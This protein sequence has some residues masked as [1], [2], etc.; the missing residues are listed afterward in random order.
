[1]IY[2]HSHQL[3][4]FFLILFGRPRFHGQ[5]MNLGHKFR[6]GVIDGSMPFKQGHAGKLDTHNNQFQLGS[7]ATTPGNV[8]A[9]HKSGFQGGFALV[10]SRIKKQQGKSDVT[11]KSMRSPT[12]RDMCLFPG[13]LHPYLCFDV[14]C[15]CHYQIVEKQ[16]TWRISP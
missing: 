4:L 12:R 9:F 13:L 14:V 1:M 15:N 2:Y 11:V 8:H 3:L 16:L 6:Q 10:A 7:L 5:G